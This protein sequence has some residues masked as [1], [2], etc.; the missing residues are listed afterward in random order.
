MKRGQGP[1]K[2][3]LP[4]SR[5]VVVL[6]SLQVEKF[7]RMLSMLRYHGIQL[8]SVSLRD[9]GAMDALSALVA[10]VERSTS[11]DTSVLYVRNS[12][13]VDDRQVEAALAAGAAFLS[14][15]L[16]A[17]SVIWGRDTA[18]QHQQDKGVGGCTLL[19]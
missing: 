12:T 14:S 6:H 10:L 1:L 19:C 13:V 16:A 5:T 3:L 8:C 17:P 9:E 18:P 15:T 2:G 11:V 7:A 4:A